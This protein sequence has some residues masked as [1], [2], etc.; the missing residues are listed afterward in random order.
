VLGPG[1][2]RGGSRLVKKKFSDP[3]DGGLKTFTLNRKD[4]L[5]CRVT[6]AS[7]ERVNLYN[8]QIILPTH[9]K[10]CNTVLSPGPLPDR[11]TPVIY[12]D[13]PAV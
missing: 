13:L 4:T 3:L 10:M 2:L 6:W 9:T 8:G 11:R 1:P 5:S 7:S 12:T